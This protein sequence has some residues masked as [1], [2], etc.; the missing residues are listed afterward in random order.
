MLSPEPDLLAL[1]FLS[2]SKGH[3]L[4]EHTVKESQI[5]H[6]KCVGKV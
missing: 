4:K 2:F 3:L 6:F 1:K 5:Q